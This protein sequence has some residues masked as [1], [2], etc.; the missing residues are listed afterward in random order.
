MADAITIKALQDASLDAKSLEEV[1]NGDEAK[2]VTTRKGE[3]Y[4]SVKKAIN[5]LFENGGLPATPFK[6][7]AALNSS[8]LPE[9]SYAIVTNDPDISANALY[10]KDSGSWVRSNYNNLEYLTQNVLTSVKTVIPNGY[11]EEGTKR[12]SGLSTTLS[13]ESGNLV[14]TNDMSMPRTSGIATVSASFKVGGKYLLRAKVKVTSE[15]CISVVFGNAGSF[16]E[17][18]V[19]YY[20]PPVNEWFMVEGIV[21]TLNTSGSLNIS[22]G[23][24]T[25]GDASG[26]VM[27]VEFAEMLD[28]GALGEFS[29][30]LEVVKSF[31]E[32]DKSPYIIST[33]G[34]L[35]HLNPLIENKIKSISGP[36][37][38]PGSTEIGGISSVTGGIVNSSNPSYKYTGF[39]PLNG[40]TQLRLS[41]F[42]SVNHTYAFYDARK[43]AIEVVVHYASGTTTP[44]P[45]GKWVMNGVIDV[46][47]GA[48][49][50]AKTIQT[51]RPSY[52]DPG[53]ISI[54]AL[55]VGSIANI[56]AGELY[57]FVP[58]SEN[59]SKTSFSSKIF[60]AAESVSG[61]I[62][63]SGVVTDL[64]GT[65]D[66]SGLINVSG[67]DYVKLTG[68]SSTLLERAWFD[69]NKNLLE[70]I[71]STNENKTKFQVNGTYVIPKTAVYFGMNTRTPEAQETNGVILGERLLNSSDFLKRGDGGDA[72]Q[73]WGNTLNAMQTSKQVE[74]SNPY[75]PEIK[76][77]KILHSGKAVDYTIGGGYGER[78]EFDTSIA[79]IAWGIQIAMNVTKP[80]LENASSRDDFTSKNR[81]NSKTLDAYNGLVAEWGVEGFSWHVAP[82]N[83]PWGT[84]LRMMFKIGGHDAR[85]Q[86]SYPFAKKSLAQFFVPVWSERTDSASGSGWALSSD[87]ASDDDNIPTRVMIRQS[88][89]FRSPEY[90]RIAHGN[91]STMWDH[92]V[93]TRG[94][95]PDPQPALSGDVIH[96]QVFS[97]G[98]GKEAAGRPS[99]KEVAMIEVVYKEDGSE[100]EAEFVFKLKNKNTGEWDEVAKH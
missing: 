76:P 21:N 72:N 34:I 47:E 42:T 88:S 96:K 82:P 61:T 58:L 86:T 14:V 53:K 87:N 62:T 40:A 70:F 23:Y 54:V 49:Y 77:L 29:S 63:E 44:V 4:P 30:D 6:T 75:F 9:G 59:D 85:T 79:R 13:M 35:R 26:K 45:D 84:K 41:G 10:L 60:E 67:Y 5:T 15:K 89:H 3:T 38:I 92:F 33:E 25:A 73:G 64:E 95:I 81:V 22:H 8:N 36:I 12:W 11:F 39:V 98:T 55:G 16:E 19:R 52:D 7:L 57:G 37:Y 66:Y 90:Y 94:T 50:F 93:R 2:Q 80:G 56:G 100:Y 18:Y 20:N 69:K 74:I 71:S 1:V 83:V 68:F 91:S 17:Q 28:L 65:Y 51:P 31:L 46:P 32:G 97:V 43:Q 27:Y 78:I 24:E 99:T 48:V